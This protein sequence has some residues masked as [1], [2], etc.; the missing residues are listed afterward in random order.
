MLWVIVD[1]GSSD[2]TAELVQQMAADHSWITLFKLNRDKDRRPGTAVIHAFNAGLEY[3]QDTPFDFIVKL[4]GDLRLPST[5]F[6]ELFREFDK[7]VSLGI[8]SGVYLEYEDGKWTPV[9]MPDY[10]AACASKVLRA[11]CFEQIGGFVASRGWDT[12]DEI[13]AQ[14]RGWNTTHFDA[15]QFEHLK[16]EGSGIGSLRTNIMHGEI[17]YLTGGSV[18]FFLFKILHRAFAGSPPILGAAA[19]LFGFLKPWIQKRE[20]LVTDDEARHYRK[21]LNR[22]I[23]VLLT[24]AF[25]GIG[26]GATDRG[27]S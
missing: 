6:E 8:A 22:R 18:L 10:H 15:I 27:K 26:F 19:M 12:V 13:R 21:I 16:P 9:A 24:H 14:M 23:T 7:D 4:D 20:R 17:Y 1:D 5:Y 25:H 3:L 11:A 2:R